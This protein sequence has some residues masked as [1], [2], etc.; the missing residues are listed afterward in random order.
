MSIEGNRSE[1]GMFYPG[2][3]LYASKL[4]DLAR[5]AGYGRQWHST[6]NLVAQ[7]PFGTVDLT[8]SRDAGIGNNID[9]PFKVTIEP[10]TTAGSFNLYIRAGT[11]NSF[12]PKV[13][14][15]PMAGKY[16]DEVPRPYLELNSA[17]G[18]VKY[19]VLRATVNAEKKFFPNTTDVYLV[20]DLESI[21]DTPEEG[22]IVIASISL[23]K[24]GGTIKSI[25]SINQFIYASLALIR[26]KGGSIAVWN[27]TS[28]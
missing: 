13:F 28:R 4:N 24:E 25:S 1:G 11:V 18:T 6:G 7:G 22:K 3:I 21:Y 23:N 5:H 17:S 19:V 8:G 26:V 10:G 16:L 9:Y 20:D 2:E 12:I 27:W 14:N 15:G